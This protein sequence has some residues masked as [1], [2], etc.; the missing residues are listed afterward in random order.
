MKTTSIICIV[1]ITFFTASIQAQ[2]TQPVVTKKSIFKFEFFSPMTGNTTFAYERFI[3]NKLFN[4][5]WQAD[6]GIVGLGAKIEGNYVDNRLGAFIKAGPKLYF[7]NDASMEGLYFKPQIHFGVHNFTGYDGSWWW[8]PPVEQDFN[9]VHGSLLLGLGYQHI[10]KNTF[11]VDINGAIGY[12]FKSDDYYDSYVYSGFI[13]DEVPLSL[14]GG[15][16]IGI[17]K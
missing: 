7:T 4:L 10:F 12:G 8:G 2:E 17:L 13:T 14:S 6:L 11:S 1:A 15:F 16:A 3:N 9:I 5:S